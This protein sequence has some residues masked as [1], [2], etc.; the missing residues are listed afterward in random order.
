MSRLVVDRPPVWPIVAVHSATMS[1]RGAAIRKARNKRRWS[2]KDL[3]EAT[4]VSDRT[5]GRIERGEVTDSRRI[6]LLEA[7]LKPELEQLAR[8]IANTE[9]GGIAGTSFLQALAHLGSLHADITGENEELRRENAE[10]RRE[11]AALGGADPDDD[12]DV[13]VFHTKDAPSAQ[14]TRG[15]PSRARDTNGRRA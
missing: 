4:G 7:E 11:V 12:D 6:D 1:E 3:A 8:E 13:E 5:I 14:R 9:A 10:L 15:N 2:T